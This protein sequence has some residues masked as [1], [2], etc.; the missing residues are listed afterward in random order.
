MIMTIQ[1]FLLVVLL[2]LMLTNCNKD[3]AGEMDNQ[4]TV[5]NNVQHNIQKEQLKSASI[6]ESKKVLDEAI[7]ALNNVAEEFH[8]RDTHLL[9]KESQDA[10]SIG[11]FE[12]SIDLSE[13]VIQQTK[14]MIE[15]QEFAK[16]N[17]QNLVPVMD[18]K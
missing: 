14:L 1:K 6:T 11:D 2:T 10:L 3:S 12:L 17:W 4:A 18:T 7:N 9:I 13:K 8:W 5:T 15:Q 16:N